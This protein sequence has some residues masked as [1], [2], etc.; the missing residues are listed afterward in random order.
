MY[1]FYFCCFLNV[2]EFGIDPSQVNSV[3]SASGGG[4]IVIARGIME[5]AGAP[6]A[7]IMIIGTSASSTGLVGSL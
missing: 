4:G 3:A 5:P 6:I 1:I 7:T 2:M